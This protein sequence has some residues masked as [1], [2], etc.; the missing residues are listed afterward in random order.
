MAHYV[1]CPYCNQRFDR[2][3]EAFVMASARRY[4]HPACAKKHDE[5]KSQEQR[6]LEALEKYIMQLFDEPYVNAKAKRQINEFKKNYNYTYSGML[7]SLIFWFEIKGNS[8][9]KANGGIGIIPFIYQQAH[10]YYYS[11][12][13]AKLANQEKNIEEYKPKVKHIEIY[14]PINEPKKIKLFNLDDEEE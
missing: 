14:A 1:I 4:A 5:E 8:I 9:E 10:D 3:K 12:Y 11:L 2:D 6:D 7:K 13:L